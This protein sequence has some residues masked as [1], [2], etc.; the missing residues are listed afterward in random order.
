MIEGSFGPVYEAHEIS[1]EML[2]EK[3]S[4]WLDTYALKFQLIERRV[5]VDH[6]FWNPW[7]STEEVP[8]WDIKCREDRPWGRVF[9]MSAHGFLSRHERVD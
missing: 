5:L 8:I 1:Q 7:L 2:P 4:K 6:V 9:T 3:G